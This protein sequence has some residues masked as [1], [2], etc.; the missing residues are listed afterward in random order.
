[1]DVDIL[2]SMVIGRGGEWRRSPQGDP[3][4]EPTIVKKRGLK[5]MPKK[6]ENG[7]PGGPQ[8]GAKIE[9]RILK[10]APRGVPEAS[11]KECPKKVQKTLIC[12]APW[13]AKMKLPLR[14]EL[15][16]HFFEGPPQMSQKGSQNGAKMEPTWSQNPSKGVLKGF[17]KRS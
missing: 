5:K 8:K 1:M 3:K 17:W 9:P 11:R 13:T 15:N 4:R 12:K 2:K 7:V 14:R 10:M 16:F 6:W